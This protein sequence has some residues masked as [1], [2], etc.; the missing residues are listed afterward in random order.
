MSS[1]KIEKNGIRQTLIFAYVVYFDLI[2]RTGAN[3]TRS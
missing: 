1:L 3:I 2:Y